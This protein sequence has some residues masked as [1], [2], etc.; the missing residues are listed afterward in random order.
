MREVLKTGV[1]WQVG[2]GEHINLW[3][4][5]WLLGVFPHCLTS[6]LREDAPQ[7]VAD[8]IDFEGGK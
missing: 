7:R 1:H 8:L 6:P 4:N 5:A 2:N 3:S